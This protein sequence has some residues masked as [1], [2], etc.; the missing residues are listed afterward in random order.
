M[1]LL[2]IT[3][4]VF[5]TDEIIWLYFTVL[6]ELWVWVGVGVATLLIEKQR[7][8]SPSYWSWEG[9]HLTGLRV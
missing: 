2:V 9:M 3:V 5:H 8:F 4:E 1:E 6:R 7:L